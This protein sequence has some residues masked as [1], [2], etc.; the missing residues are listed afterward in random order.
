MSAGKWGEKRETRTKPKHLPGDPPDWIVSVG[1]CA[2]SGRGPC[3]AARPK[4]VRRAPPP[5]PMLPSVGVDSC[6]HSAEGK[7]SGSEG[8]RKE[9]SGSSRGHKH[10]G[11]G[12]KAAA[13][14]GWRAVRSRPILARSPLGPVIL[15]LLQSCNCNQS[16][17]PT[18]EPRNRPTER[19]NDRPT[20][21][22]SDSSPYRPPPVRPRKRA[23][24]YSRC[25]DGKGGDPRVGNPR[26][27]TPHRAPSPRNPPELSRGCES[28]RQDY[29]HDSITHN[30][31]FPRCSGLPPPPPP[32]P[33]S[34]PEKDER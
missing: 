4:T 31:D 32:P 8:K 25:P 5:I 21:R 14:N 15:R 10:T 1:L 7:G 20:D 17:A 11:G 26:Y 19:P 27:S 24:M 23:D 3:S 6:Q 16:R 30:V 13:T 2:K 22:P 28:R 33:S 18:K 29:L 9:R 34:S 12:W